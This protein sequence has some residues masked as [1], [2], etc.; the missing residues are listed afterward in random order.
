MERRIHESD[1][2]SRFSGS[3]RVM[4]HDPKGEEFIQLDKKEDHRD[5]HELFY[6]EFS[7][8]YA[9]DHEA[10]QHLFHRQEERRRFLHDIAA[11]CE[12]GWDFSSKW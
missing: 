11:A 10:S 1:L 4:N 6:L 3:F 2:G 8:S 7:E 5:V 9:E 12:S